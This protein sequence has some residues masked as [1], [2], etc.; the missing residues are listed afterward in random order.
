[1]LLF[2]DGLSNRNKGKT[3]PNARKLKDKGV[4]LLVVAVGDKHIEGIDEMANMA[5]YPPANYLFRVEK[6]KDFVE[7]VKMA[8]KKIAPGKYK[9][10]K[11]YVSTCP[12]P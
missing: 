8:I 10:L 9:I 2:T 3:I 1:M 4:E 11:N 7:V 6:I 12:R 5:T